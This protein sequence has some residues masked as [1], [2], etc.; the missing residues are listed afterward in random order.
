MQKS[1][2]RVSLAATSLLWIALSSPLV[3]AEKPRGALVQELRAR[4]LVTHPEGV[5]RRY[6]EKRSAD[7]DSRVRLPEPWATTDE[8]VQFG[9]LYSKAS[10]EEVELVMKDLL[11]AGAVFAIDDLIRLRHFRNNPTRDTA[12]GSYIRLF[13]LKIESE[14]E[15]AAHL[16]LCET[17]KEL[18]PELEKLLERIEKMSPPAE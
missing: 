6:V 11:S 10:E 8:L 17:W 15:R 3:G 1:V 14:S 18:F 5:Y 4:L 9:A 13:P 16:V 2:A 12:V 7:P